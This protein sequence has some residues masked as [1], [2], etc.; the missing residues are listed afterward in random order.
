M[1][2]AFIYGQKGARMDKKIYG[3]AATPPDAT[4][5][6]V[7]TSFTTLMKIYWSCSPKGRATRAEFW[8][9]TAYL[10]LICIPLAIILI[11]TFIVTL[12]VGMDIFLLTCILYIA[13]LWGLAN[14]VPGAMLLIRRSHD[15]G[16]SGIIVSLILVFNYALAI[17]AFLSNNSLALVLYSLFGQIFAAA[18][19]IVALIRGTKDNKYGPARDIVAIKRGDNMDHTNDRSGLADVKF[20]IIA[21]LHDSIMWDAQWVE[22]LLQAEFYVLDDDSILVRNFELAEGLTG[23]KNRG[24]VERLLPTFDIESKTIEFMK[25]DDSTDISGVNKFVVSR[26]DRY[27]EHKATLCFEF[28]RNVGGITERAAK[29][30]PRRRI[31]EKIDLSASYGGLV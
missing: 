3:Q 14:V 30:M 25:I 8:W 1:V 21:V 7:D 5:S 26:T 31:V 18:F 29:K 20:T 10:A 22:A 16:I 17:F 6:D 28:V 19:I 4:R 11:I 23:G 24:L 2:S 13:G 15:V 9:T 12:L 27:E